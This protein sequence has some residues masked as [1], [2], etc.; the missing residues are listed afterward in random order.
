MIM[1]VIIKFIEE[2]KS[3]V[4]SVLVAFASAFITIVNNPKWNAVIWNIVIAL[5]I[6]VINNTLSIEVTFEGT[7]HLDVE[8]DIILEMKESEE[9]HFEVII[10]IKN[11]HKFSF[12]SKSLIICIPSEVDITLTNDNEMRYFNRRKNEFKIPLE[13]L[14]E[15]KTIFNIALS[16]AEGGLKMKKPV[17]CRINSQFSFFYLKQI[18]KLSLEWKD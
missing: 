10:D 15:G 16:P 11:F 5:L 4:V 18:N 9:S 6:L 3:L 14:G 12:R 13:S 17:K 8:S 7:K 2:N 1:K